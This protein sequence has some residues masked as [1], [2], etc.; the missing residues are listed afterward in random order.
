MNYQTLIEQN[1]GNVYQAGIATKILQHMDRIRNVSDVSQARRWVMEL[2]QNSRDAAYDDQPVKIQIEQQENALFFSHSGRP[3]R[4]KDI[5]SIINQVSSKSPGENT[6]GQF[7]TGFMTTYQL[8]EE[9]EIQSVL[10][11]EGLPFKPFS[12][13]MDRR[14]TTKEEILAGIFHTMEELKKADESETVEDFNR[15]GFNTRFVYHLDNEESR[16]IARIGMT[17]LQ[18]TI[19][20]VLLFSEKI[21]SVELISHE[22]G[23]ACRT[24]YECGEE[25]DLGNGLKRLCIFRTVMEGDIQEKETYFLIHLSQGDI[26]LAAGWEKGSMK[27]ISPCLPRLF[28]D[29]PL[30]GAEQFPFPVVINCRNFRTNEPRSG[31][32]LVDNQASKDA[33]VNKEIMDRAVEMYEQFLHCLSEFGYERLD[34]VTSIPLWKPDRE[35]SEA[36]AREHL[37]EKL[38]RIVSREPMISTEHGATAFENPEFYL[39]SGKDMEEVAGVRQLLSVLR[40]IRIPVGDEDWNE[41]FAGYEPGDEKCLELGKVVG[42]AR[43]FLTERL[44]EDKMEPMNWCQFLYKAAMKNEG[45]AMAVKAGEICIFPN[46]NPE[47]WKERRLFGIREIRRDPGIPEILKQVSDVLDRLDSSKGEEPLKIR[48]SLLHPGFDDRGLRELE[49]YDQIRMQNHIM[50][51]TNRKYL[52]RNFSI[53]EK[54]YEDAWKQAWLLLVACGE[55]DVLY[56]LC[57]PVYGEELPKRQ[58]VETSGYGGMW[59]NTYYEILMRILNKI[60]N[61]NCMEKLCGGMLSGWTRDQVYKWLNGVYEKGIYYVGEANIRYISAF[62]NQL[63]DFLAPWELRRDETPGEELKEI[64]W[65]FADVNPECKVY[66]STLDRG[67]CLEQ[68][69]GLSPLKEETVAI[70]IHRAVQQILSGKNLSDAAANHQE[71]CTRLLGWIQEHV[72]QAEDYFPGFT[73]EEEQMKL[74]T[75]KAAVRIQKKARDC[76]M[77]LEELEAGTIEE[78][79]KKLTEY[80]KEK[81]RIELEAGEE[82]RGKQE[83]TLWDDMDWDEDLAAEYG[84][85]P[86]RQKGEILQ[87]I[88]RAG[89]Q[90][91]LEQVKEYFQREGYQ[92]TRKTC[93]EIQMKKE[94]EAKGQADTQV[95]IYYPDSR[96]YHQAGWDIQVCVTKEE[97]TKEYYLEVK[98]HTRKSVLKGML[99]LSNEQMKAAAQNRERYTVLQVIYDYKEQA[100]EEIL[101]YTDPLYLMGEGELVSR[102]KRYLLFVEMQGIVPQHFREKA[103]ILY[104]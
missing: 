8:S 62:P 70:G 77:I 34:Y 16:N 82:E 32:T 65:E 39:V 68:G 103:D 26:T 100:G 58:P 88:G 36:W 69:Y 25:E 61:E 59:R 50:A 4:V 21:A 81:E 9:V 6:I 44:E 19:L 63:G 28:V 30:I 29:F 52:V 31:I 85:V 66:Q 14:G 67:I 51:R 74:L 60:S 5:L 101:A 13:R 53:Y 84:E 89:E 94:H 104:M 99:S 17:D 35:I 95:R 48:D 41:A 3:F 102:Q 38:Y 90:Y 40:G 1:I 20:Y 24:F 76:Q 80:K 43:E 46:Q 87:K 42:L 86:D 18:E 2:F 64:A 45:L 56:Q 27:K 83:E 57:M 22:R 54:M 23:T 12:I 10:K 55:D 71:A 92:V 78:A 93:E 37:Y 7:G 33:F 97:E 75:P 98:T 15:D 79:M 49:D 96:L 72:R 91:A 11:D 47:D 73:K